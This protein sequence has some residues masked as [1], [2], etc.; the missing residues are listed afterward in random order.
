M[1]FEAARRRIQGD[2]SRYSCLFTGIFSDFSLWWIC[3]W[4]IVPS[5]STLVYSILYIFCIELS[6]STEIIILHQSGEFNWRL[7]WQLSTYLFFVGG[8]LNRNAS[9]INGWRAAYSRGDYNQFAGTP[10]DSCMIL[11][12]MYIWAFE[13]KWE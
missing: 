5:L 11:G 6:A 7:S 4:I 10:I 9:K 1:D 2:N 3:L 12:Y 8:G 13:W